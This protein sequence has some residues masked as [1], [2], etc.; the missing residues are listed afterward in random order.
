MIWFGGS[1][2]FKRGVHGPRACL[3]PFAEREAMLLTSESWG[4]FRPRPRSTVALETPGGQ[5]S[6]LGTPAHAPCAG[7]GCG[8][9]GFGSG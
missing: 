4:R 1:A 9:S 8:C 5:G 7:W 2:G 3:G 6:G